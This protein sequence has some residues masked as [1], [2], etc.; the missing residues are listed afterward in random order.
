MLLAGTGPP[1]WL[2]D[3]QLWR[4]TTCIHV[5]HTGIPV[6]LLRGIWQLAR[7]LAVGP[8]VGCN[9]P[10]SPSLQRT[11]SAAAASATTGQSW[12]SRTICGSVFRPTLTGGVLVG[13][14]TEYALSPRTTAVHSQ[15]S[16]V[17]NSS[18]RLSASPLTCQCQQHVS[19]L[20]EFEG[21]AEHLIKDQSK[22]TLRWL[23]PHH[24][25]RLV[26]P[27]RGK[28]RLLFSEARRGPVC[29]ESALHC[30]GSS[31]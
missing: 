10:G 30:C 5:T 31:I 26:C 24:S 20:Q 9:P 7:A 29:V 19:R 13:A 17:V 6:H 3:T 21:S 25:H 11:L 4:L 15:R 1:W 22:L 2:A 14:A 18:A 16:N 23:A 8:P 12:L 28:P 27:C